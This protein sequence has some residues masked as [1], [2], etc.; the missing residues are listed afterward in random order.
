MAAIAFVDANGDTKYVSATGTG[1]SGDPFIFGVQINSSSEPQPVQFNEAQEIKLGGTSWNVKTFFGSGSPDLI[2]KNSPGQLMSFYAY[3]RATTNLFVQFFDAIANPGS[4]AVPKEPFL[5]KPGTTER[6]GS[7][8]FGQGVNFVNGIVVG[9]STT[10]ATY[11]AAD[12][13]KVTW[14]IRYK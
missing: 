5:I 11:T 9:L 10:E 4:G 14:I 8:D 3:N 2:I 1:T 13:S 12:Y 7:S 6:F